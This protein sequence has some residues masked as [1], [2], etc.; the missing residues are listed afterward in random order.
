MNANSSSRVQNMRSTSFY[1][2][3][4]FLVPDDIALLARSAKDKIF[5]LRYRQTHGEIPNRMAQNTNE[6][7]L[8]KLK[9]FSRR[10]FYQI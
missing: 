8:R 4:C 5:S 1:D 3:F 7:T 10:Q 2:L 9:S 6:H